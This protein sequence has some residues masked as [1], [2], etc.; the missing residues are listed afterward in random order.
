MNHRVLIVTG[1]MVTT[2]E[3]SWARALARQV[4]AMRSA[5]NAWLDLESKL[6][7]AGHVMA[8]RAFLHSREFESAPYAGTVRRFFDTPATG[9]N[10]P[11]ELAEVILATLLRDNGME[12]EV[13]T[14][15][16][17]HADTARRERHLR[18]CACVFASTTLL[19][20]LSELETMMAMLKRPWNHVVAGGAL[21]GIL[22]R[23]WPGCRAIDVLATGYAE[24]MV[25]ALCD[26]I[27]GG[28][29]RLEAPAGGRLES[30]SGTVILQS[31]VPPGTDLDVLP[32]PDWELAGRVHRRVFT[33]VNYE[34]VRGCPYRCSFCNYP[35]LFDDTRFRY[36]SAARIAEDWQRLAAAGAEFVTCLDSL[37]T[38]PRRRLVELCE[39]LIAGKVRLKWVCYA[40]AD[41]LADRATCDLMKAAG[42]HQ[43]QI[44][45]E[46][47][48]QGQLDRM[49][50]RVTVADNIRALRN[51]RDAGLTTLTSLIIG[52]PGETR[53]SIAETL[54]VLR[55][56]PPDVYYLAP[57]N[58]RVEYVP[59][60]NPE[61]RARFGLRT[62]AGNRSGAPYWT[63]DTMHCAD[64]VAHMEWL[65][66]QLVGQRVALE[67]TLFYEGMLRYDAADR[68]DL[69]AFQHDAQHHAPGWRAGI[70]GVRRLAN[71]RLRKDT[72]RVFGAPS[73]LRVEEP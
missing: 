68:D 67:G 58:V 34:S 70:G 49:N 59:V 47:G 25:P 37:F 39:R 45:V 2:R 26:W 44:G 51:C 11:P 71:R 69:L 22:H 43:V 17:L 5:G 18:D 35:L 61:N 7:L 12:F 19:R 10:D 33:N 56:A 62:H 3:R 24:L 73:G 66:Q 38:M 53:A 28:F 55:D 63:H 23:E 57:F 30:R 31:G 41:D 50:K 40:R 64:V 1:G 36:R 14:Y 21:A 27:R 54:T 13:A 65:H 60:L 46:S 72:A 48:S 6:H 52:F 16:D 20:D 8:A 15:A 29:T 42:C 4:R 32:S 9:A